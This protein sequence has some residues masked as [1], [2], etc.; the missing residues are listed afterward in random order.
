MQFKIFT[1]ALLSAV[2]VAQTTTAPLSPNP[3]EAQVLSIFSTWI[4]SSI[5]S[6]VSA[7]VVSAA[8]QLGTTGG[9]QGIISAALSAATPPPWVTLLPTEYQPNIL[10]LITAFAAFRGSVVGTTT[11]SSVSSGITSSSLSGNL[12]TTTHASTTSTKATTTNAGGAGGA[13]SSSS[14]GA[15]LP[16]AVVPGAAGILGLLG[17]LVAL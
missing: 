2:A 8:S 17:V 13:S 15:A 5:A 1:V 14:S 6:P 16:S 3:T 11:G 12:T 10:G 4:P 9:I 7:A